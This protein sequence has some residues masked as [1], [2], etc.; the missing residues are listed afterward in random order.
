MTGLYT[1]Y[2]VDYQFVTLEIVLLIWAI[3]ETLKD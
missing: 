1:E 2:H 3:I